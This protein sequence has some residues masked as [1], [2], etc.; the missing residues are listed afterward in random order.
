M[1]KRALY[2]SSGYCKD[3]T[4]GPDRARSIVEELIRERWID[5]K[6]RVVFVEFTIYNPNV[7]MFSSVVLM[8]E[9][10]SFGGMTSSIFIHTFRLFPYAGGYGIFILVTEIS[11]LI[12][13]FIFVEQEVQTFRQ[14]RMKCFKSFWNV[15]QT[16]NLSASL[17]AVA[18]YIMRHVMTNSAIHMVKKLKGNIFSILFFISIIYSYLI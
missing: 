17:V 15:L 4:G 9:T 16:L 2:S 18:M 1:G 8:F 5:D 11:C 3:L 14:L 10:P 7:N 12:F 13:L 6:T